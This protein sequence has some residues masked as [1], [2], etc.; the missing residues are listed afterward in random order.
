MNEP[1][2]WRQLSDTWI[3]FAQLEENISVFGLALAASFDVTRLDTQQ[4][5]I[6]AIGVLANTISRHETNSF[7]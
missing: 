5:L 4:L 7:Q 6:V 2:F 1:T 3:S